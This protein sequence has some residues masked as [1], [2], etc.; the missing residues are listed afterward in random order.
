[1]KDIAEKC[2]VS[3]ATVSKALNGQKDIGPETVERIRQTAR[4]MGYQTNSAARALRTN[5][6]YNIGVLFFDEGHS[7]LAHD[8]FSAVLESARVE[9]ERFGYDIT[10]ISANV[11]KRSATYLQHCRYRNVDGVIIACVDFRDPMV[12]ELADSDIPL[13]TIDHIFNNR[14]AIISD[15]MDGTA[16]LTRHVIEAGHTRIA[17][18]HG[19]NTAVTQNRLL[20]FYRECEKH[21]ITIREEFVRSSS[22]R[23][24]QKCADIVKELLQDEERPTCIML[25]DDYS[26][27]GGVSAIWE[28]G[29]RIPEDIS[30]VGYD[31]I[32]VA[33]V[34]EPKLT[35]WRQDTE[36][37]GR[38]AVQ[39][40]VGLIERP[41]TTV[42][43][44]I[45]VRGQF[46]EGRSLGSPSDR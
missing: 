28:A 13:V 40:L 41:K 20:G 34:L 16:Q 46:L 15:N 5:R 38:M 37:M 25:P 26:A 39:K 44:T 17:F 36:E 42:P 8:Y 6:T 4:E 21:G 7:G 23:N 2:G 12:I 43:E 35:T 33:K 11:G 31:G 27:F 29:L 18:I 24:P 22:Y 9:A 14:A 10:F 3:V 32:D 30:I 19:D 1:M 45:T